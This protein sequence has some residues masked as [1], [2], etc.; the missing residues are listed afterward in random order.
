MDQWR[1]AK[2][3]KITTP[4]T[5]ID[6]EVSRYWPIA[7]CIVYH[8][9]DGFNPEQMFY[10]RYDVNIASCFCARSMARVTPLNLPVP[11]P[12]AHCLNGSSNDMYERRDVI[13]ISPLGHMK[14]SVVTPALKDLV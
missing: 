6:K 3:A 1:G 10:K 5:E 11:E 7:T 9:L 12:S 2:L 14:S 8:T 13:H 4:T